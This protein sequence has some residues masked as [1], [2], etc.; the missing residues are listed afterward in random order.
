LFMFPS[1]KGRSLTPMR[2]ELNAW[3]PHQVADSSRE[4]EDSGRLPSGRSYAYASSEPIV[5]YSHPTNSINQNSNITTTV[6][7][8]VTEDKKLRSFKK[9]QI[10]K[11]KQSKKSALKECAVPRT[12]RICFDEASPTNPLVSPCNCIGTSAYI[13]SSCLLTWQTILLR[14]L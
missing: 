10:L 8:E 11:R 1:P 6:D 5:A 7:A 9:D 12:C 14:D 3:S 4:G 2:N 13:H